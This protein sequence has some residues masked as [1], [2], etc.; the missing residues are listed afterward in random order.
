M[1]SF[2]SPKQWQ[3]E[4]AD[5]AFVSSPDL[6]YLLSF[7]NFLHCKAG[8]RLNWG[9]WEPHISI[10]ATLDPLPPNVRRYVTSGQQCFRA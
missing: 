3:P 5:L 2:I 9:F 4:T 6:T 7:F 10:L 1:S 8:G